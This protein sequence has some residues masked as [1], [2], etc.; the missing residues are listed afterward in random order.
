MNLIEGEWHQL[1]VYEL[2]GRMFEDEYDLAI[3]VMTG[4]Q[5]RSIQGDY[6]VERFLFNPA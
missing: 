2:I 6:E 3:D 5:A 1:K 4:I